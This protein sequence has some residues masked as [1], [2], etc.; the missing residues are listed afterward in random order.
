MPQLPGP[1][2]SGVDASEAS[3]DCCSSPSPAAAVEEEEDFSDRTGSSGMDCC[4]SPT[5]T[6]ERTDIRWAITVIEARWGSPMVDMR[7]WDNMDILGSG[8]L[9]YMAAL[10][11]R[12]ED[13]ERGS[14][15]SIG[16]WDIL[17]SMLGDEA[18]HRL[19]LSVLSYMIKLCRGEKVA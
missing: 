11:I 13:R 17:C 7:C 10:E 16:I 5:G 12:W 1:L 18:Y 14:G 9:G 2:V 6:C 19:E 3:S 15:W 8:V 4:C